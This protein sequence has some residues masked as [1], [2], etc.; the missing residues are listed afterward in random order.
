MEEEEEEEEEKRLPVKPLTRKPLSAETP[1]LPRSITKLSDPTFYHTHCYI[2]LI[3]GSADLRPCLTYSGDT[4]E[5]RHEVT[6]RLL[7]K[8]THSGTYPR[9]RLPTRQA[10]TP[11]PTLRLRLLFRLQL[12]LRLHRHPQLHRGRQHLHYAALRLH[13]P[14][15]RSTAPY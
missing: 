9:S 6:L 11:A 12:Q 2:P 5:H 8:D 10:P 1:G 3:G 7:S 15:L 13:T 4:I 14:A